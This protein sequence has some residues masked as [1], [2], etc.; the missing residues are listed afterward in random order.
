MSH[1]QHS[2][3]N[4]PSITGRLRG[5][6]KIAVLQAIWVCSTQMCL[7]SCSISDTL[8][9]M[10]SCCLTY[11]CTFPPI[12][13]HTHTQIPRQRRGSL[14]LSLCPLHQTCASW[15]GPA[16]VDGWQC[17]GGAVAIA[18]ENGRVSGPVTVMKSRAAGY[19]RALTTQRAQP[20]ADTWLQCGVMRYSRVSQNALLS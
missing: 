5:E 9:L 6:F 4:I 10:H 3:S 8:K 18:S 12:F 20:E 2:I 17:H 13:S 1:L 14:R 15:L 16:Q 19:P 11:K 7:L